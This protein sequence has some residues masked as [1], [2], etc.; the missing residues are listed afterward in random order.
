MMN[1]RSFLNTLSSSALLVTVP[2]LPA[3]TAE[4]P[5]M[6]SRSRVSLNGEWQRR[7]KGKLYDTIDVPSSCRPSGFY[8]LHREFVL[9]R[10]KQGERVFIHF[11]GITYWG[12]VS[13]NSQK[14]GE[15]APYVPQEF[16][17][18]NVAREGENEIDVAIADLVPFAN[19]TAKA[20]IRFG[21]HSGFEAYGGI[22]RDVWVE[23]RPVS[24]VENVRLAY[25]LRNNYTNC[26]ARP[27]VTISSNE[28]VFAHLELVLSRNGVEVARTSEKYQLIAGL[29]DV[30]LK[31]DIDDVALWSPEAPN[32]Y[33]MKA[34][35]TTETSQDSWTCRTGLREIRTVGREFRLNGKRLVLNGVCRHDM[36]KEQGFTLSRQQQ[37]QDM[38]MIKALGCNFVRLVHYPHH[39]RILDLAD[40]LG[41]LVSE[42]PGFWQVNFET[43]DRETVELG[44]KILETTIKRDWNSPC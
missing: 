29:T 33:E 23:V 19:G 25:E 30:E 5:T 32:L 20:Q 31:L 27:K 15:M 35:L 4:T 8:T 2:P 26:T 6:S 40:E 37:D 44:Y 16:E 1:R 34:N 22:I 43:V 41:L 42:E 18:T 39:H 28:N 11:E 7:I 38:R 9:Q 14:L 17:F 10:L 36:W 24:F 13:M 12:Q 21:I 3:S